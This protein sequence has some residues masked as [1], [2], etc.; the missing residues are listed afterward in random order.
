L[1]PPSLLL[2]READEGGEAWREEGGCRRRLL[3]R[4]LDLVVAWAH[5]RSPPLLAWAPIWK[6]RETARERERRK[7]GERE[8]KFCADRLQT[9]HRAYPIQ[10]GDTWMSE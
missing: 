4:A 2:G 10:I 6:R 3:P 5:A 8:K 9:L 7:R 1:P